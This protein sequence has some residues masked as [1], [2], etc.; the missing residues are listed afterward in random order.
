MPEDTKLFLYRELADTDFKWSRV[1][2]MHERLHFNLIDIVGYATKGHR[3]QPPFIIYNCG[4]LDTKPTDLPIPPL[5]RTVEYPTIEEAKEAARKYALRWLEAAGKAPVIWTTASTNVHWEA[6]A[7]GVCIGSYYYSTGRKFKKPD[8]KKW[9]KGF[10]V[11]F[12]GTYYLI[13]FENPEF[14]R[15]RVEFT[16]RHWLEIAKA[17]LLNPQP[18]PP[19]PVYRELVTGENLQV[20][21]EGLINGTWV[22]IADGFAGNAYISGL[23]SPVRR[24]VETTHE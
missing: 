4:H 5:D 15:A 16:W 19:E 7:D 10:R 21:D 3:D 11:W 13:D 24:L 17:R 14:A 18:K 8:G 6:N 2:P 22:R 9:H 23:M 1:G 12:G 20:G